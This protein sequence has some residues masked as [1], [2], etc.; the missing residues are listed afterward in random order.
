MHCSCQLREGECDYPKCY[1]GALNKNNK[2]KI[3]VLE[4]WE[5]GSWDGFW[6]SVSY[7]SD[8]AL[9]ENWSL[10]SPDRDYEEL[11]EHNTG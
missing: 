5:G 1:N 4:V 7:T 10:S 9:A 2:P 6:K 11:N 8:L 3:Y